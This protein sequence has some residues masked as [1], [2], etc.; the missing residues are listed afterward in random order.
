MAS[1]A[2]P[3][4]TIIPPMSALAKGKA[5]FFKEG[6]ELWVSKVEVTAAAVIV[7]VGP[8]V[9]LVLRDFVDDTRSLPRVATGRVAF[10]IDHVSY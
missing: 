8:V 9:V 6:V 5:P 4:A 2:P 10:P 3:A 1:R 7:P